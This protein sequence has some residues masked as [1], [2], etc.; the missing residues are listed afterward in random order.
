[1]PMLSDFLNFGILLRLLINK[2][3]AQGL[4]IANNSL[5]FQIGS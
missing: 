3:C 5:K 4:E 2:K 1:M